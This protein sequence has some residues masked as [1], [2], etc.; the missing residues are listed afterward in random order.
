MQKRQTPPDLTAYR[1]RLETLTGRPRDCLELLA[2]RYPPKKIAGILNIGTDQV[3]KHI[4][5]ARDHL[6]GIERSEAV[7]LFV[8][9][10][11]EVKEA[12]PPTQLL[13]PQSLGLSSDHVSQPSEPANQA[14]D[15]LAKSGGPFTEEQDIYILS[16]VVPTLMAYAPLRSSGRKENDLTTRF[17]MTTVAVLTAAALVAAGSAASLLSALNGMPR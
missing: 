13:A 6:G 16:Q 1:A 4:A 17:T 5:K 12:L 14:A 10:Q 7:R 8:A 3:Y 11:A 2:E 15:A 9:F